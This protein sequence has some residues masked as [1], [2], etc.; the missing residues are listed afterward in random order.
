MSK[1]LGCFL[2]SHITNDIFVHKILEN[3]K[4]TGSK[5]KLGNLIK[6]L[7]DMLYVFF[8]NLNRRRKCVNWVFLEGAFT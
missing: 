7:D 2:V 3:H 4:K 8:Q 6:F 1:N 5:D